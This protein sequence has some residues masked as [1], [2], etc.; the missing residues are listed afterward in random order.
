MSDFVY[1]KMVR[2]GRYTPLYAHLRDTGGAGSEDMTVNG[3]V[4][5]V[6]FEVT[7]ATRDVF[8]NRMIGEIKDGGVWAA[9][10]Y[11]SLTA[12][13]NGVKLEVLDA[14]DNVLL[15]LL[16][17]DTIK[18]NAEW[19]AVCYDAQIVTYGSGDTILVFRWT[20][21]K[22]GQPL[23]LAPTERLVMTIQ[24]NLTTLSEQEMSVRG[25]LI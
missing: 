21:A 14:S 24:D 2:S 15:D 8:I 7:S 13:T 10:D 3:S 5:P 25:F 16:D 4:T 12:L 1:E 19:N 11:G 18:Y 6:Q 9:E 23:H 17:G 22:D 20:F